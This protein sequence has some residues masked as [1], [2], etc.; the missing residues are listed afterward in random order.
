MGLLPSVNAY[1]PDALADPRGLASIGVGQKKES[2][3]FKSLDPLSGFEDGFRI[4][5]TERKLPTAFINVDISR[6]R[7]MK[8]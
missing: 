3:L 2:L 1:Y 4:H 7:E 6:R 5:P 8:D